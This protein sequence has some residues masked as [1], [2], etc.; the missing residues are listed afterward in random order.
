[1][2]LAG[3]ASVHR[4]SILFLLVIAAAG[5]IFAGLNLPIA[6]FPNVAFPR[7]EVDLSAGEHPADVMV[8]QVTRPAEEAVRSIAG[9]TSVRSTTSR[10][11]AELSVTFTWG[12]DMDRALG[13]VE[14]VISRI[15][16]DL[17]QGSSFTA[18]KMDPTVFPVAAY[19]LLSN[20]VG[21]IQLRD[22]AQY[23]LLPLLSAVPGV[24]SI[25]VQG[26]DVPEFRVT[27][28]PSLLASYAVTMQDLTTALARGNVL[29]VVGKVEDR[30]ELLLAVAQTHLLTPSAIGATVIRSG[31]NGT[32]R[33]SDVAKVDI[34]PE[35]NYTV[36]TADG[37]PAV[38]L[39]VYQQPDG[40][41]V[42][43][44]R[45]VAAALN[46]YRAKLPKDV[47]IQNWYDQSELILGSAGSVR[48]AI[49]IGAGLAALVLF[50]FLRSIRLTAIVLVIVPVVLAITVLVLFIAGMSFNIMT[51]GGM[52]AA[53]GLI[54]D[55]DIV[56]I[57]QIER[58]LNV[59]AN[60]HD[61]IRFAVSEFLVPLAGSSSATVVIF[62]PL[63]FLSGVTG[64]FFKALSLTMATALVVSFFAAWFV[65][66]LIADQ[67]IRASDAESQTGGR[68]YHRIVSGYRRIYA[69][70]EGRPYAAGA[71][72]AILLAIG[73]LAW[74]NT[75]S[76]FMP[77]MDEGGF[78]L[79]YVSPPGTS[80]TDTNAMVVQ[81]E[82]IIRATPEVQTWSRRTGLQL[83]GGL[84]E[85]NTGDFFI[86]LKPLPRRPIDA[87]MADIQHRV[88]QNVSGLNIE[89]AQLMEDLIGD[90][91]SVPQPVE[92]KLF[93]DDAVKLRATAEKVAA[94]IRTVPGIT[95][96]KNGIVI[97]G[98][99]LAI[100]VNPVTAGLEGLNPSD[101]ADQAE[102]Y[103][104]GSVATQV[105][106]PD[107]VLGVR[108]WLPR[109][110]RSTIEDL[111]GL[112]ISAADGH[113]VPLSRIASLNISTGE[114]EITRENL[115]MM[116][117]VTA[118]IEGRDLGSTVADVKRAVELERS[119]QWHNVL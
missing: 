106:Q 64:A 3:W 54:I 76:G 110:D 75:G 119:G 116:V 51:L 65:V 44:V 22:I 90:L 1:M 10:G 63:A 81:V 62:L 101:V 99:N 55:D 111:S 46:A 6:L 50:A 68:V 66:P 79:D 24:A 72:V 113:A 82:Q 28:R 105:Q 92:I 71:V 74:L 37:R 13:Q 84:T 7:V 109:E 21:P 58:R 70:A 60:K 73:V 77:A 27:V 30:H 107:R 38:L 43:I 95:E 91:T 40:N 108:V 31:P 59:A 89:T 83:G 93:G 98:S 49:L 80:L 48:D 16:P 8:V 67:L 103:I 57:E 61:S 15:M 14:A 36:V 9:V 102:T 20:N 25:L 39:N 33:L 53:I 52:A 94:R 118:R 26:G 47:T 56:M 17:P 12:S 114:P 5:G 86:R 87:V 85:A 96:V 2:P 42:Q 100:D 41:T 115:K 4:R 23:Q 69:L 112:P 117:P 34:S 29:R 32:I 18:R 104:A 35:P 88:E 97:A 11:S 78:I 45:G 19:S